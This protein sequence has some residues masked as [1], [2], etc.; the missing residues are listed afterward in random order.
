M[1]ELLHRNEFLVVRDYSANAGH[2]AIARAFTVNAK[3]TRNEEREARRC[4]SAL[5]N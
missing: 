2:V 1:L 3:N 5:G 4:L